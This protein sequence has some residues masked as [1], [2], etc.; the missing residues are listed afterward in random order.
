M[1]EQENEIF[2]EGL[3][4]IKVPKFEKVSSSAP[5]FYNPKMEFNRDISILALQTF[6][7]EVDREI[8][9]CDV[10]GGSGIRAIR[11]KKE[12]S[13]VGNVAVNDIS[14]LAIEQSLENSIAN[15]VEIDIYQHEANILLRENR[16]IFD[17]L[18]I[19]PFGTT[20]Y[21]VDSV[22]YSL[23]KD[24]LLC[25]TATDTSAL[26][27]T[28]KEPC[29]RKYNAKPYKSEYCHENGIR[30]LAGFVALTIAKYKKYIEDIKLSHSSE[31]YMRLYIKINK[32]SAN[33]D[34]SLANNIGYISHCKKCLYRSSIKVLAN[35]IPENCPICGEKLINAGPLWIG[36]LQ[37]ADFINKMIQ[38]ID[39][40]NPDSHNNRL[41]ENNNDISNNPNKKHVN[42]EK[43]VLKLLNTCLEEADAPITFYD[44]HLI[45]RNL[46]ISAPKLVDVMNM[47]KEEGF[48]ATKTH[49]NPIGIKSDIDIVR[50]KEI[51]RYLS[52]NI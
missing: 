3:V 22:G 26:C 38:K 20:S 24:S 32:G 48:I 42:T 35:S 6:Q 19:D 27:G 18:D 2:N 1:D 30:I 31:H 15:D 14:S 7:E 16:G 46:K 17:V 37:N 13:D 49:F 36:Y 43:K 28:Y 11:Y 51:V 21:F 29:I 10:F 39:E 33:T 50:L 44:I 5:V 47:M 12:I 25:I 9:I 41:D 45:C 34:E 23:K 40:Y 8:N 52:K 4:E